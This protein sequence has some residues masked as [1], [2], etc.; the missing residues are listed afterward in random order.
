MTAQQLSA[1]IRLDGSPLPGY[2]IAYDYNAQPNL[3]PVTNFSRAL[4][5]KLK[6]LSV[7][8]SASA[9]FDKILDLDKLAP[10]FFPDYTGYVMGRVCD[11]N[12]TF[13]I[14]GG[15]SPVIYRAMDLDL[16]YATYSTAAWLGIDDGGFQ[17]SARAKNGYQFIL[18][19]SQCDFYLDQSYMVGSYQEASLIY[20]NEPT[21]DATGHAEG[22]EIRFESCQITQRHNVTNE[23]TAGLVKGEIIGEMYF[24]DP[25][26]HLET[27]RNGT[28]YIL[29]NFSCSQDPLLCEHVDAIC[30]GGR[31]RP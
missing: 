26:P 1:Y 2:S 6:T 21:Y 24:E 23:P 22:S 20:N 11:E 17:V 16:Q 12:L 28:F 30:L 3:Y 14:D 5:Y 15:Y 8:S 19:C 13:I 31:E 4:G 10:G 7:G 25:N 9:L 29:T 18:T 27:I